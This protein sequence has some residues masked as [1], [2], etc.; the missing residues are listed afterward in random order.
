MRKYDAVPRG[1]LLPRS[2]LGGPGSARYEV[3]CPSCRESH[4]YR[5]PSGNHRR[6]T[7]AEDARTGPGGGGGR[8][9]RPCSQY[10]YLSA[11]ERPRGLSHRVSLVPQP[12][13]SASRYGGVITPPRLSANRRA[14]FLSRCQHGCV[15]QRRQALVATRTACC[16]ASSASRCRGALLRYL[17]L[18]RPQ[19]CW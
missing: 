2:P 5:K 18:A 13:A 11:D 1:Q 14:C 19:Y 16:R 9:T 6:R 4:G 10:P 8:C 17:K 12:C 3:A 15:R 7:R